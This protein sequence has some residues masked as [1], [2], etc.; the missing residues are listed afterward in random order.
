MDRQRPLRVDAGG[1]PRAALVEKD[2]LVAAGERGVD[3]GV[4][5]AWRG[6]A[7]AALQVEQ[8]GGVCV[9]EDAR[10]DADACALELDFSLR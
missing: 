3:P 1:A 10:E 2:H 7:R 6:R 9:A 5:L 8:R 4:A